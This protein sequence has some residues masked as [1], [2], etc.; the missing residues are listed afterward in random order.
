MVRRYVPWL[1]LAQATVS[2]TAHTPRSAAV[3]PLGWTVKVCAKAAVAVRNGRM[4]RIATQDI[5]AREGEDRR[6]LDELVEWRTHS[7]VP[8]RHSC[9]REIFRDFI[10]LILV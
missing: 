6:V 3:A 2:L 5:I 8:R 1:P 7:C 10:P 9:R 4:D